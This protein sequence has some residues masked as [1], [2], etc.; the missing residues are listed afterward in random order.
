MKFFRL[1][2]LLLMT[3]LLSASQHAKGCAI[4]AG[5]DDAKSIIIKF[6]R[7]VYETQDDALKIAHQYIEFKDSPDSPSEF[8]T[9]KRYEV[10]AAH[11]T[12]LRKGEGVS[13]FS[14]PLTKEE[15]AALRIVP[16]TSLVGTGGNGLLHFG[17]N[18]SQSQHLYVVLKSN[19]AWKYFYVE[20]S[21]I[22]SFDYLLK[23]EGGPA[24]LFGY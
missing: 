10:A 14:L 9:D 1:T 24:Y 3:G 19:V 15:L 6:L 18:E 2:L 23:D 11:I 13:S 21:K 8:S 20:D 12:L 5:F 7:E 22:Y 17:L 16:Y 4:D